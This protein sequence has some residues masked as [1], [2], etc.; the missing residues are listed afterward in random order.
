M[1]RFAAYTAVALAIAGAAI[2]WFVHVYS[3][4]RATSAA[5]FHARYVADAV[6]R[7]RL[8]PADI[9]GTASKARKRSVDEFIRSA[10]L[11]EGVESAR[12]YDRTGRVVYASNVEDGRDATLVRGALTGEPRQRTTVSD[13]GRKEL[14]TYVPLRLSAGEAPAGVLEVRQAY[15]PIARAAREAAL[16]IGGALAV[17]LL[18]LYASLFPILR[19]VTRELEQRNASLAAQAVELRTTLDER[20]RAQAALRESEEQMRHSQK[21]EAVGRL[22]GGLAHDMNNLLMAIS[23]HAGFLLGDSRDEEE[24]RR[25]AREIQRAAERA[26]SLTR[27]LLAFGRRQ[28]LLPEVLDV[29]AV[30]RETTAMLRR[31]IGEHIEV[32]TRLDPRDPAVVADAG[33]LAQVL[34]NLVVNAR[35]AIAESGRI[36]I[37]SGQLTLGAGERPDLAEGPYVRLTVSDDGVGMSPEVLE[38]IWEPFYT[39]KGAGE[40]T[41]LGLATVYGIVTQSGGFVSVTSSPGR[42]SSFEVLLPAAGGAAPPPAEVSPAQESAQ[43]GA[44]VLLVEDEPV[45]MAV[46]ER[47]LVAAG[48]RV[49]TASDGVEALERV[50]TEQVDLVLSDLTM[51]RM[52]GR[53]LAARLRERAPSVKVVLASGYSDHAVDDLNEQIPVLQKPFTPVQLAAALRDALQPSPRSADGAKVTAR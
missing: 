52:G 6:L 45:V 41:G 28:V 4:D 34:L 20:E 8:L 35:D 26:A 12:I 39:T 1:L 44:R 47:M 15:D 2:L 5:E 24:V 9:R 17:A 49:T 53:E 38:R 18:A 22:A 33:Q 29:N 10:V 25:D 31:L 7:E 50:A 11:V 3:V 36:E 43:V 51:P 48:H 27:Q 23:A 32:V 14:S 19:R 21:M 37:A 16:P 30:V 13:T 46:I 42:G 40:G